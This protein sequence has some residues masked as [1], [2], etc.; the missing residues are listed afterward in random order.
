MRFKA[1]RSAMKKLER[2]ILKSIPD[3][4]EVRGSTIESVALGFRDQMRRAG[5]DLDMSQA[6]KMAREALK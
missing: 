3:E 1:N 2:D 4:L 6:R 5:L